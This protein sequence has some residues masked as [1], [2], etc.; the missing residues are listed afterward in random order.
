MTR[1]VDDL[2]NQLARKLNINQARSRSPRRQPPA[3]RTNVWCNVCNGHG[4]YPHECPT[5][6]AMAYVGSETPYGEEITYD[7]AYN[8]QTSSGGQYFPPNPT[9]IR[10]SRTV[11]RPSVVPS[12]GYPLRNP[13]REKGTCY[14]CGDRT[15]YANQCP[16]PRRSEGYV[17]IC[18]NCKQEGHTPLECPQPSQPKMMVRFADSVKDNPPKETPVRLIYESIPSNS[19]EY[20]S[21]E[22]QQRDDLVSHIGGLVYDVDVP[23]LAAKKVEKPKEDKDKGENASTLAITRS[24]ARKQKKKEKESKARKPHLEGL[25]KEQD[26]AYDR[27]DPKYYV[28]DISKQVK[29]YIQ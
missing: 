2:S 26:P 5:L 3:I 8:M 21:V 1:V 28:P 15:H 29:D 23:H 24:Q 13:P 25:P 6:R 7:Y 27:Y 9:P 20:I 11:I 4:H 18:G 16:H 19:C 17:P 22:Y 12:G 14:N 10:P